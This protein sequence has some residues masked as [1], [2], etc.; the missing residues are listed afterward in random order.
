MEWQE[1]SDLSGKLGGHLV[2]IADK[3]ENDF[4]LDLLHDNRP[5]WM[6]LRRQAGQWEWTTEE[7]LSFNN[8][9]NPNSAAVYPT[10]LMDGYHNAGKWVPGDRIRETGFVIEWEE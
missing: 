4:L 9:L 5:V 1:A 2:T 6:G 8:A 7:P 3:A 10:L